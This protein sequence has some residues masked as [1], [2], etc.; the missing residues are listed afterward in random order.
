MLPKYT[1]CDE[2]TFVCQNFNTPLSQTKLY[3]LLKR[4]SEEEA[5]RNKVVAQ[6]I[7]GEHTANPTNQYNQPVHVE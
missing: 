4:T 5:K 2:T 6:Y 1:V 7:Q 3:S